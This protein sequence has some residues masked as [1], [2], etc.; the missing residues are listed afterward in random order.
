MMT[1]RSADHCNK[2]LE[3]IKKNQ[4]KSDNLT[5]KIKTQPTAINGQTKN[6]RRISDLKDRVTE[7]TQPEQ[8]E[9]REKKK[10]WKQHM[11]STG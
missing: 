9:K 7:V 4:S 2:E 6:C 10:K 3:T 5:A 11:R 8:S 1:D